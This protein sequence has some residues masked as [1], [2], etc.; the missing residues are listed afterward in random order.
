[1]AIIHPLKHAENRESRKFIVVI[2]VVLVWILALSWAILPS[3]LEAFELDS[4]NQV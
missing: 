4:R 2:E 3:I 1:M